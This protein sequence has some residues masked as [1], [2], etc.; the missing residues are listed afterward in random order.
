MVH[1]VAAHYLLA[2]HSA[3]IPFGCVAFNDD[4]T[5]LEVFS[6]QQLQH[7]PCNT[8]FYNGVVAPFFVSADSL[9]A[10]NL[11]ADIQNAADVSLAICVGEIPQ[12][13]NYFVNA[14]GRVEV[15]P[16]SV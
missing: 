14:E 11:L 5:V 8:R 12:L 1:R 15:S 7:E 10:D 13:F 6:L 9:N 16:L 3:V 2:S 4:G